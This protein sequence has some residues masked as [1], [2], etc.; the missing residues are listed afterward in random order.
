[1]PVDVNRGAKPLTPKAAQEV[2][3][4]VSKGKKNFA[5]ADSLLDVKNKNIELTLSNKKQ[6][7]AQSASLKAS[8]QADTDAPSPFQQALK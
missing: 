3:A 8:L 6:P 7:P 2:T 4:D 1:M 5:G